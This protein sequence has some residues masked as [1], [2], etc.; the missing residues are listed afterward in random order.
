MRKTLGITR[1]RSMIFTEKREEKR[2]KKV[3]AF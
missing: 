2:M 1:N 3:N